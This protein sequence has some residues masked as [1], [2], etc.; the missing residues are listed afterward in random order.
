MTVV[1][2]SAL[3]PYTAQEMFDLVADIES[4]PQFLPWCGGARVLSRADGVVTAAVDIA[5]SGVNKSFTTRNYHTPPQRIQMELL[6]GPF[7]RLDGV[8]HFEALDAAHCKIALLLEFEFANMLLALA[9]NSTFSK[10][11][12]SMVD[13]FLR[14]AIEV[15]GQR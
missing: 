15:Y 7:K 14:R 5:Y 13:S 10:I 2:K 11:A 9:L 4:Y 8:W 12:D 1:N 6:D 3:V